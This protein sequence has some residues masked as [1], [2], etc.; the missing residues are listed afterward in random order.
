MSLVMKNW[1]ARDST[2]KAAVRVKS[3][4]IRQ[5]LRRGEPL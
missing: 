1:A 2:W 5:R 4:A 3:D